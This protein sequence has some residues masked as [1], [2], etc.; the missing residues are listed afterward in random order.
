[1]SK[2][3]K[4]ILIHWYMADGGDHA[5]YFEMDMD[6]VTGAQLNDITKLMKD[7]GIKQWV[8]DPETVTEKTF[9]TGDGSLIEYR[10]L[11]VKPIKIVESWSYTSEVGA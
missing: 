9:K 10:N 6:F 5:D 1:M 3:D 2:H 4:Y 7:Y 8:K 11:T